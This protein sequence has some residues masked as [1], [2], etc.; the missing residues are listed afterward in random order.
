M[1]IVFN[2]PL[3]DLVTLIFN[4][5]KSLMPVFISKKGRD[6]AGQPLTLLFQKV[7]LR[8]IFMLTN[9]PFLS[10]ASP[11]IFLF[12]HSLFLKISHRALI[13]TLIKYAAL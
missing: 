6:A 1:L 10:L 5:V 8:K 13:E 2:S 3:H 12:S 4:G 11:E 9:I 7:L